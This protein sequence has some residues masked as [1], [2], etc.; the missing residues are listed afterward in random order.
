MH[1][2][3]V[4]YIWMRAYIIVTDYKTLVRLNGNVLFCITEKL[5]KYSKYEVLVLDIIK[6]IGV[7]IYTGKCLFTFLNYQVVNYHRT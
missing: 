1:V 6:Y 7:Y 2:I 3:V 5:Y 4:T